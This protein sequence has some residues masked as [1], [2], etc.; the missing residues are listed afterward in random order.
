MREAILRRISTRTFVKKQLEMEEIRKIKDVLKLV[1]RKGPFQ[2]KCEITFDLNDNSNIEGKKIGTYGLIK[3]IPSYIGGVCENTQ[4]AIIDFG[5][6]FEEIILRLT[7]EDFATCWVGGTFRRKDYRK[8]LKDNQIIPAICPVGH[9]SERRSFI[10]RSLRSTIQ[11][12]KRILFHDLFTNYHKNGKLRINYIDPVI[13][14]LFLVRKGPSASNKQPWRA[15]VD[16]DNNEVH[17]YM[18]RTPNYA[19]MLNYD[20]QSLDMGIALKHFELGLEHHRQTF[21]RF[22]LETP[23]EFLGMEYILSYKI[24]K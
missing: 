16:E 19:K 6:V 11:S 3:N 18:K 15:F 10:D 8:E 4:E 13:D 17:F 7:K 9:R 12:N 1:N 14:S 23:K 2:N 20:I 22:T 24:S 5:Y 21:K